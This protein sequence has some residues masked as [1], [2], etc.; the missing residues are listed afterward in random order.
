MTRTLAWSAGVA[1]AAALVPGLAALASPAPQVPLLAPQVQNGTVE[2][3]VVTDIA[4]DLAAVGGGTPVWVGWTVPMA[5]GPLDLCNWYSSPS[6]AVR[7]FF[8]EPGSMDD[9]RPMT[10]AAGPVPL[11]AGHG[12]VVLARMEA[13]ALDRLRT[14]SDDCPI[15][16]GGR[17]VYW[18][19]GVTPAASLD[20]LSSLT[21]VPSATVADRMAED[22]RRSIANA[23]VSAIALHDSADADRMLERLA[24]DPALRRQA[25]DRMAAHRGA[26]GF[27]TISRLLAAEQDE[28]ARR[29]FVSALTRTRQ[30]GTP[31]A[32]LRIAQTDADARARGD[33]I[34]GYLRVTGS[35][36][37]HDARVADAIVSVIERDPEVSVKRRAISGLAGL[38]DDAGLPFL[39]SLARTSRDM[40]VKKEVVSAVSKS[41]DP[42]VRA[43]LTEIIKG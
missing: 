29:A 12:L 40:T 7:G 4:R 8:A 32:L 42:R 3:R 21:A 18:L 36:G 14:L 9:R 17:T 28:A 30:P 1:V 38:P 2:R 41:D 10:P 15:D 31:D 16:A 13:G 22:D 34:Y 33:A 39:I 20:W 24:A 25:A 35:A 11:E 5:D 23:A 6:V 19:D 26:T 27:E 43:L 37:L